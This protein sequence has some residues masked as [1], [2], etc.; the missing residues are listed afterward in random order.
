M[1]SIT[2]MAARY[3][4]IVTY[5]DNTVGYFHCQYQGGNTWSINTSNGNATQVEITNT[6]AYY[7]IQDDLWENLA[8]VSAAGL[9]AGAAATKTITDVV[10]MAD[11][12][13]S[14]DDS[15]S[16]PAYARYDFGGEHRLD[17]PDL[18]TSADNLST[19]TDLLDTMLGLIFDT[20]A[21]TP[22]S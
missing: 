3:S 7:S 17:L 20:A 14:L 9:S 1:A 15:T 22:S 2:D 10:L 18:V 6:A 21:I 16:Y 19:Y 8:F 12:L 11:F 4:G 13:F 5:S